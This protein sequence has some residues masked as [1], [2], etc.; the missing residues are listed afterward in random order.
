MWCCKRSPVGQTKCFL[1][2]ENEMK[3]SN[4]TQLPHTL[5]HVCPFAHPKRFGANHFPLR[6]HKQKPLLWPFEKTIRQKMTEA[7]DERE[8]ENQPHPSGDRQT[9]LYLRRRM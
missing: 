4:G 3:E 9:G 7:R 2:D 5:R 1:R 6:D 8:A